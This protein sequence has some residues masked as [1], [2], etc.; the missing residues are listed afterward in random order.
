MTVIFCIKAH[1][2]LSIKQD[3]ISESKLRLPHDRFDWHLRHVKMN[4][5]LVAQRQGFSIM[6]KD[7]D[8]GRINLA[9]SSLNHLKMSGQNDRPL[10]DQFRI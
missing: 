3:V 7:F 9:Q 2:P 8:R 1:N 10:F 6:S 5:I 4:I